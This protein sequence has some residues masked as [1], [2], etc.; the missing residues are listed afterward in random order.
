MIKIAKNEPKKLLKKALVLVSLLMAMLLTVLPVHAQ[1]LAD[2]VQQVADKL[3]NMEF[4]YLTE[5]ITGDD[6]WVYFCAGPYQNGEAAIYALGPMNSEQTQA[7]SDQLFDYSGST[8]SA[9]TPLK[10]GEVRRY[11]MADE[12]IVSVVLNDYVVVVEIIESGIIQEQDFQTATEYA[13]LMLDAMEQNGLL[14]GQAPDLEAVITNTAPSSVTGEGVPGEQA[15]AD[16]GTDNN[17]ESD[18]QSEAP[19]AFGPVGSIPGPANNT[20][21]VVGVVVPGLVAVAIGALS[22][23][24][25]SGAPPTGGVTP[26]VRETGFKRSKFSANETIDRET[27]VD[28]LSS[29]SN[30]ELARD[31]NQ[32]SPQEQIFTDAVADLSGADVTDEMIL[33]KFK[34]VQPEEETV[35]TES[36]GI[37]VDTTAIIQDG[38]ILSDDFGG[39]RPETDILAED[40]SRVVVDDEGNV[41]PAD[42]YADVL[43]E[44]DTILTDG[45]QVVVDESAFEPDPITAPGQPEATEIDEQS[46]IIDETNVSETGAISD[47]EAAA[48]A[49]TKAKQPDEASSDGTAENE[50]N[51]DE[52]TEKSFDQNGFDQVGYDQDGFDKNGYNKDGYDRFGYKSDGFNKDGYDRDG[53]DLQGFDYKGYN[54]DGYDP[55]GYDRQGYGKDGFHWSGYTADGY[56]KNGKHWNELGYD[57]DHRNPF[58]GGPVSL[59]GSPIVDTKPT[60]PPLGQP[61]PKTAEKFGPKSWDTPANSPESPVTPTTPSDTSPVSTTPDTPPVSTTPPE[62]QSPDPPPHQPTRRRLRSRKRSRAI[63]I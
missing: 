46:K 25:G 20:E 42:G 55:F 47:D 61:Y 39:A 35:V 51:K 4:D 63:R 14:G 2:A 34:G 52:T 27:D 54:R 30:R 13:Q 28:E 50:L 62:S 1:T 56:D 37:V 53:Y 18:Y 24:A 7:I 8:G 26:P 36:D 41:M 49:A 10:G 59:D 31:E 11:A 6:L 58:D 22:G 29:G 17:A 9:T 38:T 23:L 5:D 33:E 12:A 32:F 57:L 15:P 21:A 44:E 16:D 45:D 43:P 48:A 40:G 19:A 60:A 3:G